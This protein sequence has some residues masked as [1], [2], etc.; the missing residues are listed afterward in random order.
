MGTQPHPPKGAE[1]PPKFLRVE[2]ENFEIG[3]GVGALSVI[4][5]FIA[6][7]LQIILVKARSES[8]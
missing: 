4:A 6:L 5:N 7:E 3:P 1:P 8:V 2:V